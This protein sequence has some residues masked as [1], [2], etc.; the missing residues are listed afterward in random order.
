M[1]AT[2]TILLA[3]LPASVLGNR[4]HAKIEY[5]SS[6]CPSTL[7]D[8]C[9][10]LDSDGVSVLREGTNGWTVLPGNPRGPSGSDGTWASAHEAMAICFDSEGFKWIQGLIADT[11]PEMMNRDAWLYMYNG[12]MGEDNTMPGV[13]N[14][15]DAVQWIESGPHAMLMPKDTN[16]LK[17]FPKDPYKGEPYVMWEGSD[18]AHLMVPLPG[19]YDYT[20]GV[21]DDVTHPLDRLSPSVSHA[22]TEWKIAAFSSAC[23]PEL[24]VNVTVLDGDG[25]SVLREGS[26]GWTVLP[27][28]PRGPSG[29]DGTWASAHEAMAICFDSEGLAWIEGLLGDKKPTPKRDSIL[30]MLHGD[31][32]EDNTEPGVLEE[33]EAG[34][35]WIESGPHAM[36]MPKDTTS[37]AA[38]STNFIAGDPYVMWEGSDYAHVMVPLNDYYEYTANKKKN[39]ETGSNLRRYG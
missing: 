15:E 3:A 23:P 9:T 8:D 20:P 29:S 12:D 7:R 22:T 11:T 10:V 16:S 4:A 36:L 38:Y 5:F 25:V 13:L 39:K 14:E 1:K 27:G 33:S 6:A 34:I 18:Y 17:K 31:M 37:L 19:Y 35:N 26:N 21:F 30:Y 2:T 28:N 32:G 24:A